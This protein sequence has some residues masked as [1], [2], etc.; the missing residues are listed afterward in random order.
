MPEKIVAD[1]F[2]LP[3]TDMLIGVQLAEDLGVQVGDKLRVTT[4]GGNLTLSSTCWTSAIA[5]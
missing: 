3:N 4:D 1:S 2:H 5:V